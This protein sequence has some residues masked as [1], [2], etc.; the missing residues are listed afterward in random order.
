MVN[1]RIV[2]LV[3]FFGVLGVGM[4]TGFSIG[5]DHGATDASSRARAS[6]L[7]FYDNFKANAEKGR[8]FSLWGYKVIP[9]AGKSIKVCENEK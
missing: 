4:L 1:M 3:L 5:Y 9:L 6:A 8:I 2:K 7:R